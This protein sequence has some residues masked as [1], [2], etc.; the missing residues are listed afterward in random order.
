MRWTKPRRVFVNSM[1]DLFHDDVPFSF[2]AEVFSAMASAK[3][4]IFQVLTKRPKRMLKFLSSVGSW[5]GWY[6]HNGKPLESFG[7][8]GIMVSD[9]RIGW[10]LPNVWL[11][12]SIED[13]DTADER[14]P[15][16]LQTPAAVRWVSAEPL[17]GPVDLRW[18]I[19]SE[20]TGRFRTHAG[21]RQIELR[22][23]TDGGGL[24]WVV[25]GGESGPNARPMHPDWVRSLRDQCAAAGV[26]FLFKQWGEWANVWGGATHLIYPD[27]RVIPGTHEHHDAWKFRTAETIA[28]TGR[29]FSGRLL[30]D[31][32][33][34]QYPEAFHG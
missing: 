2:V 28:R 26:P 11:G 15:L 19:F 32:T 29:K 10:P 14:I 33:H 6:T 3:R 16:L 13:Q 4:H 24:H 17:L 31:V 20:P 5:E 25:A 18:H 30:D 12:V 23:P 9:K 1:G 34:D 7:G 21:E 27:G 22:K 8:N